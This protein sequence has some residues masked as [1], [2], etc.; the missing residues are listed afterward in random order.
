[1]KQVTEPHVKNMVDQS[2]MSLNETE[3]WI[4]AGSET[5]CETDK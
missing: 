3:G 4:K 1:M 2:K 5:M